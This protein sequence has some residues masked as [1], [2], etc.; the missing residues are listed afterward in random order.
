VVEIGTRI[1][2]GLFG[3]RHPGRLRLTSYVRAWREKKYEFY[4]TNSIC[5]RMAVPTCT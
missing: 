4:D 2:F 1:V 3:N 5:G